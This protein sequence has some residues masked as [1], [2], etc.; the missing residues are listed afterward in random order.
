MKAELLIPGPP[1][2]Q[3]RP[4]LAKRGKFVSAYVPQTHPV[5]EYRNKIAEAA[6]ATGKFFDGPVN[7]HFEFVFDRPRSHWTKKGL[8]K[9]APVFPARSDADNI[10]KAVMDALN[11]VIYK[12]DNQVVSGSFNRYYSKDPDATGHTLIRISNA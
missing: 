1:V 10:M 12:D 9:G 4:R 2:A 11:D 8:R 5:H 6:K 3:P 7:I